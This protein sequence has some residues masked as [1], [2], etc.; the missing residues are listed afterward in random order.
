MTMQQAPHP[1]FSLGSSGGSWTLTGADVGL[2]SVVG[3][4]G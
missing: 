2:N 4:V 1:F 3:V